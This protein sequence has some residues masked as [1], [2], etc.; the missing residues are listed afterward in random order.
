MVRSKMNSYVP[1]PKF[2]FFHVQNIV[3][4]CPDFRVFTRSRKQITYCGAVL[5]LEDEGG[6]GFK[7]LM[8]FIGSFVVQNEPN[9]AEKVCVLFVRKNVEKG[10]F[11]F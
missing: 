5:V 4:S 7:K 10:K 3:R 8:F 6:R 1:T 11:A 2:W 9:L